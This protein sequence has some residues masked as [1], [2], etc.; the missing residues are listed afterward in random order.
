MFSPQGQAGDNGPYAH[1][2]GQSRY[3]YAR[4]SIFEVKNVLRLISTLPS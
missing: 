4:R 1:C 2:Q 3:T